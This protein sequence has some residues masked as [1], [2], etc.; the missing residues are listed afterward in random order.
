MH[1][2]KWLIDIAIKMKGGEKYNWVIVMVLC[3]LEAVAVSWL[4]YLLY[5]SWI[6]CIMIWLYFLI[7]A[8]IKM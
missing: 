1:I 7:I 4:A 3:A 8:M 6:I 5:G 2:M